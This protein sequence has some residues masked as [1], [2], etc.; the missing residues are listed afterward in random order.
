MTKAIP[1]APPPIQNRHL[2]QASLSFS[3]E[4]LW[5]LQQLDPENIAYNSKFLLKFSGGIDPPT[6]ERALNELVHR[7]EPLRTV[8]PN[9]GGRPVQIIHPFES[10]SLPFKDFSGLPE[11]EKEP[12]IRG[13]TSDH[14][15]QPFDLQRGPMVRFAILHIT[16]VEDYLFICTHHIGF[17]AWSWQILISELMELYDAFLSGKE[18]IL[19]E[20]PIQYA[21]YAVWQREWLS[22][23]MLTTYIEHWKNILSGDLSIL[24]LPTDRARP[25]L[26]TFRGARYHFR[27]PS[28]I[29]SQLKVFCRTERM[30][31]FQV[32]LAAYA[33]LLGRYTGQ[34]DIIMGCPFANRSRPEQDG[35]VGMFVNTLPIRVD[36]QGNPSVREFLGQVRTVMLDAFTWQA[37]PFDALVS[38]IS[39]QR[40]LSRTPI[41]Q[42]TINLRDVPKR[43]IS[44]K[45]LEVENILRENDPS[46]FDISIEFDDNKDGTLEASLQYN[47]DLFDENSIIH[48]AAHYQNLL[49]ELLMK[50][51][52]PIAELEMLTPSEWRRFVVDKNNNVKDF[53]QVCIQDLIAGHAEKNPEA[54]AITCNGNSLTYGDLEKKANRL[55]HYLRA[56]GVKAECRVGIY[57]PRSEKTI[58]A[59]LA[60]LKAGGAFVPID[61]SYP[62]KRIAYMVKDSDPLAIV[63]LSHL[64]VQLPNQIRKISLD[65]ESKSIDTCEPGRPVSVTKNDSL[66]YVMYTS[67]STG[68]PKGAMNVHK[69]VVNYLTHMTNQFQFGASDRVVQFTSLSFDPSVW[70]IL[71]TLSYGGTLFLIDDN[72]MRNPDSIYAAI[73]DHQATYID[74]VPTMLRAICEF[75]PAGEQKKNNLRVITLG[76]EILWETDVELARRVFGESVQ[77]VNQYGPTE[78]SIWTTNYSI[79]PRLP[80]GLQAVPIGKPI[81]NERSYVLDNLFRPVLPGVKGE[82]FIGGIGVGCGY[83]NQ[84]EL[85]AERFL[86]DPFQPG[87]RMYRTGDIVRKLSDG[88][89]YFMGRSDDQVKIRGYRVE[90][91]EI[92]A[93]VNEF[94]G[95][96]E[97]AVV[98]WRQN[99]PETLAAY[100]TVREGQ[101]EQ[102]EDH[103][104]A[105]LADRLPFY[106]LPSTIMVLDEMPLT[107][108]RKI[109]RH[110]MARPE[111]GAGEDHFLAPRNDIETRLV[112]IW[113]EILE[114]ERVGVRDNF[115]ELGGHSLLAVRLI[116]RIQEEFGQSPPLLLLFK[117]GTVE[118]LEESLTRAEKSSY[119][120]GIIPVQTEGNEPPLFLIQTYAREL[121]IALAPGRP[122]YVV[123]ALENGEQEHQK[124][125][126]DTAKTLYH[127]LVD[128]YPQ[129]PYLLMGHSASGYFTLELAR[130]LIQS[131]QEVALLGLLDTFPPGNRRY[132]DQLDRLKFHINNLLDEKLP[133]ILQYI[134]SSIRRFSIRWWRRMMHAKMIERYEQDRQVE[135][136]R[137]PLISSYKPEPFEGRVTI[138]A[139]TNRPW[140]MRWRTMELW[141][142]TLTNKPYIVPVPGNHISML[143]PPHVA[144]LA[145]KIEA[146]LPHQENG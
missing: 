77:L 72:H 4:S 70:S 92:E 32:L 50:T 11:D 145:K 99:G 130:L 15:N 22:G 83:W 106:M 81:S 121:A 6:L 43:P 97:A 137:K 7:H 102:I 28:G 13:Y 71:G 75:V 40:D 24:E 95:V 25:V 9:Q 76:G 53:P 80:N 100:I 96:R 34:E 134:E 23:K 88:T 136:I 125:V 114:I 37:A 111:A 108:N 98:F 91:S 109:D 126:Q 29:S 84:P 117:N 85:T 133:G 93:V 55:A 140:L 143:H 45:G 128:Y 132:A 144:L 2:K 26:Q 86:S 14:G 47:T 57:L 66:A 119:P 36:L 5:F 42:V 64:S 87:D 104:H 129:G 27:L 115:F 48:M 61:L 8:Y 123:D 116:A 69:G 52:S 146:L 51:G 141:N 35:V 3:Q 112:S 113:K 78:C 124:S 12:A 110:A 19:P 46:P 49:E 142:K 94:P 68:R 10:F 131:G 101:Q 103:L 67:G 122:V 17:D 118:A 62:A 44:I 21:D 90:L 31:P 127:N 20:L 30:T 139:A 74:L 39:P 138:F 60:I 105:Y 16:R 59:L 120:R 58:V 38:E 18:P 89:I 63:T 54:L 82:L 135:G 73:I 79:P 33:L 107:P 41:F 56:N 1:P 65:S